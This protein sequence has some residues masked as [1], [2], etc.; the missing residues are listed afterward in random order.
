VS[1]I[2]NLA[3]LKVWGKAEYSLYKRAGVISAFDFGVTWAEV[4]KIV[5]VA[6]DM[7]NTTGITNS[8]NMLFCSYSDVWI[9]F[10]NGELKS[11]FV[12]NLTCNLTSDEYNEQAHLKHTYAFTFDSTSTKSI[13]NIW[14]AGWSG[15]IA[16]YRIEFWR[17]GNLL[18]CYVPDPASADRLYDSQND[19]YI[20]CSQP[21]KYELRE[22]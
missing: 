14:D 17:D 20:T 16:Y 5:L 8:G 7:V 9:G 2:D 11:S 4:N 19:V 3:T 10:Q 6:S 15:S 12:N 13:T 1:I 22:V 18:K 21:D